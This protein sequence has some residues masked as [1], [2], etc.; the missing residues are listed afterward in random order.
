MA[1]YKRETGEEQP[2]WGFG[3]FKIRLPF[4]HYRM[5][6]A[7]VVQGLVLFVVSLGMIPLLEQHLNVPYDVGL[8]FVVVC[9]VGFMLPTLLGVPML[10]GWITAAIPVVVLFLGD[11]EPGPEAIQALFALQI[12]VFLIMF[13][14]GVTRLGET[15]MRIAPASLK[16][17]I[18]I[19]AGMAAIMGE[20]T[21]EGILFDAPISLIVGSV[22][23]L[24]FMFSKSFL[25]LARRNRFL[26]LIASYGLAPPIIVAITV[27]WILAEYPRPDLQWGITTPDFV[28]MWGYLPF[29]VGFPSPEVFLLAVPT[30]FIAYVIAF[31]DMVVGKT[32]V[33][34]ADEDRTDEKIDAS[35]TRLHLVTSIRN[36]IHAFFAPYPGLAGPVFTAPHAAI[37]E[38]YKQGRKSMDSIHGGMG[39]FW[40]AGF[41]GLFVLP[42]VSAFEPVLDLALALTLILTGYVTIAAGIDLVTTSV[43]RGVAGVTAVVLALHGALYGVAVGLVLYF[44]IEW[45]GFR[46]TKQTDTPPQQ[47]DTEA[48]LERPEG[49]QNS[50]HE[51]TKRSEDDAP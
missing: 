31:G 14:L 42:L 24:V 43:Q 44:L 4:V 51:P 37:V 49:A 32:L 34:N 9:G 50:E 36:L 29:T 10:P 47:A 13:I 17:G 18:L 20:I 23:A 11:F 12:L 30:A 16:A 7:E 38:R 8:A 25:G 1:I 26:N 46:K 6:G 21:E 3:P 45:T 35:I 5:E 2:H 15:M 33:E 19:G 22:L 48:P 27:A 41:I 39:S 28:G 40:I